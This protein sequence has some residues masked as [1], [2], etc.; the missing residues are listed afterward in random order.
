MLGHR[1]RIGARHIG[2]E[3]PRPGAGRDGDHVNPGAMAHRAYEF[4]SIGEQRVWQR[5]A[6]DHRVAAAALTGE[7]VR[8][9]GACHFQCCDIANHR[10]RIGMQRVGGI[11]HRPHDMSVRPMRWSSASVAFEKSVLRKSGQLESFTATIP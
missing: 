10:H 7:C 5:G 6:H 11:D 4:R 1:G 3:Y 2:N 8:I 9:K